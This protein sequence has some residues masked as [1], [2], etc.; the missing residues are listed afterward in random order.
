MTRCGVNPQNSSR[1]ILIVRAGAVGDVLMATPLISAIR[2]IFPNSYLGFLTSRYAMPLLQYNKEIDALYDIR[3]RKLP[4][5]ISMEKQKLVRKMRGARWD[6]IF[7]LESNP[8]FA[9]LI[10]KFNAE[11]VYGFN[12]PPPPFMKGGEGEF[13]GIQF[14]P[15]SHVISNFLK[16]GSLL[17]KDLKEFPTKIYWNDAAAERIKTILNKLPANYPKIAI[18]AGFGP[19]R[20]RG[21]RAIGIRSWPIERFRETISRLHRETLASFVLTGTLK[22]FEINEAV[23][24]GLNVPVLNLAG[25]TTV[26]EL[27]ALLKEMGM[28]ISIDSSPAHIAAA[29][30]TPLIV[31]WGPAIE[32]NT[33]PRSINSP[34]AI[35]NKH[36]PC[37]PCYETPRKDNCRNNICMK[38]IQVEEVVREA[39]KL[40]KPRINTNFL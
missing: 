17:G 24:E 23:R 7:L 35:I 6:V 4:Y 20:R 15:D 26:P 21:K 16:L 31:L 9:S 8:I 36:L 19:A 40:L 34:V 30:G 12:P 32:A 13:K 18:H 22:E 38:E 5:L 10:K 39:L 3:Y 27:G 11:A 14:L 28:V 2:N 1:R 37:S 25:Q 29:V 33:S